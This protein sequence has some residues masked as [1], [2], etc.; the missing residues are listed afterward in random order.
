MLVFFPESGRGVRPIVSAPMPMR[1]W[2][3]PRQPIGAP[4][5]AGHDRRFFWGKV[6]R[7]YEKAGWLHNACAAL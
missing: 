3:R 1:I 7:E 2:G 4:W 6:D 5:E